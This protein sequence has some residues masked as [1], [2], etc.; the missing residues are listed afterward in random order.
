MTGPRIKPASE[1]LTPRE[2]ADDSFRSYEE[3]WKAIRERHI[4]AHAIQPRKDN[5]EEQRWWAEGEA[6]P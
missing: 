1:R 4:R 2:R 6:R 3:G 5:P